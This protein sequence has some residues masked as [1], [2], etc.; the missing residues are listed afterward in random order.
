MTKADIFE[1][2]EEMPCFSKKNIRIYFKGLEF[3]LNERIK[4]SLEN[5]RIAKLK[6]GLYTTDVY[7]L[8][9][10]NKTGFKEFIASKLKFPSYLSLE[11]VLSKYNLLTEATYPL[12]SITLKTGRSYQ[13]SLGTYKYSNIKEALYFGF[14]EVSFY[15]NIY[16][17]ATKAKALFDFLYLKRN[18]G[19]LNTEILESLRINWENFSFSD[20]LLFKKYVSK[21]MSKKM[22]KISKILE[23]NIYNGRN[24]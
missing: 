17:V 8:K 21:S 15:Q 2:F 23:R 22:E 4:R 7:Y 19:D 18:L 9:E 24:S 3:A 13:N 6:K 11:Y 12:T 14:K 5:E 16:F 1:P 10:P 20:F